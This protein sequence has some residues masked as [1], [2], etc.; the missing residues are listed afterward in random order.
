VDFA[1]ATEDARNRINQ[2]VSEQTLEKIK[3]LLGKGLL[4]DTTRLVLTKAV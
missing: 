3:E 4:D 2:W 1:K